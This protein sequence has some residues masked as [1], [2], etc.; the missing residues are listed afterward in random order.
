MTPHRA[1]WDIGGTAKDAARANEGGNSG[2]ALGLL[3][4]YFWALR[5][6]CVRGLVIALTWPEVAL[7]WGTH[8]R[9]LEMM[10]NTR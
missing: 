1:W 4:A 6:Q 2:L 9:T 7:V 5:G 10:C 8:W 3:W